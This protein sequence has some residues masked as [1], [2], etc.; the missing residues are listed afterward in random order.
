MSDYAA[1]IRLHP[2]AF[3]MLASYERLRALDAAAALDAL[4]NV[5]E[6]QVEPF[7]PLG[8]ELVLFAREASI[9]G[10]ADLLRELLRPGLFAGRPKEAGWAFAWILN[11]GGHETLGHGRPRAQAPEFAR[12]P[13]HGMAR[14]GWVASFPTPHEARVRAEASKRGVPVSLVWAIMREESAFKADVVSSAKAYGLMQLIVPTAKLMATGEGVSP[15]ERTLVDPSVNIALGTKLLASLRKSYA[16]NPL[17]AIAA[18]NAGGG[19]VNRW[20]DQ[21]AGLPFELWVEA[22]PYEETRG[23]MKRVATSW[24]AYARLYAA[25]ELEDILAGPWPDAKPM[26]SARGA[27]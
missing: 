3:W 1:V 2:Y 21:R 16:A 4:R 18:Y 10:R 14:L 6:S 19:A 25:G 9:A 7:V 11:A 22:I 23:Y 24:L 26:A 17:L 13:P 20:L 15:S 5:E 27:P 12:V 8:D